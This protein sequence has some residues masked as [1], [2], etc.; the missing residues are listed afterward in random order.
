[1]LPVFDLSTPV[2]DFGASCAPLQGHRAWLLW[3][4]LAYKVLLP[5]RSNDA[6]NLFQR[7]LLAMCRAGVKTPSE[8]EAR[9]ALPRELVTF[10]LEQLREMGMLA[11][12]DVPTPRAL[13]LLDDSDDALEA[14]DAGYVFV[15]GHSG[16]L[17]PRLHR[18]SLAVVEAEFDDKAPATRA[19]ARFSRGPVGHREH[20]KA[21]VLWCGESA[22]GGRPPTTFEII[23]AARRQRRRERAFA[24]EHH[25]AEPSTDV[26]PSGGE[27]ARAAFERARLVSSVPEPILVA[28]FV[29][30]PADARH[31]SW[32]ITDPCGLGI[33]DVLRDGL[34]RLANQGTGS[35][36]GLLTRL[37]GEARRVDP[38]DLAHYLAEADRAAGERVAQQLGGAARRLPADVVQRLVHA[39]ERLT[40]ARSRATRSIKQVEGYLG[41]VY[42]AL[43][44]VFGWLMGLYAD[45]AVLAALSSSPTGNSAILQRIAEALGFSIGGGT[46]SLLG[47]SRT[48]VKA[49]LD[50]GNKSLAGSLAAGL[51]AAQIRHDHPFR[52][53]GARCP[54]ALEFLADLAR[55]RNSASHATAA[56]PTLEIALATRDR[57]VALL[58]AIVGSDAVPTTASVSAPPEIAW[59]ADLILRMR[60]RA[61]HEVLEYEGIDEHQALRT[62][63]IDLHLAAIVLELLAAS[64]PHG[65]AGVASRVLDFA[66]AAAIA[67]EAAVAAIEQASPS[68]AA[69]AARITEDDQANDALFAG[70]AAA[71]GFTLASTG[72]LPPALGRARTDRIRR[73]AQGRQS[74]LSAGLLAQV[75]TA[76][77]DEAHPLRRVA[78]EAPSF[79]LDVAR[80]VEIRGHA[81]EVHL[82]LADAA[83]LRDLVRDNV[84]AVLAALD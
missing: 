37:T 47:V 78:H 71:L 10:V 72:T 4:A 31:R 5:A 34:T 40:A 44:G 42:A 13:R 61:E 50:G 2:V 21:T 28:A 73:A 26:D 76:A 80:I 46:A 38:G 45:P 52:A 9:L 84:R 11:A 67:L 6:F 48:V 54:D 62:R 69:A 49:A 25:G 8:L 17:W 39:E 58:V 7:A 43:E 27:P 82:E 53:L 64:P 81:D 66:L 3:P 18:G 79:L 83:R 16:R 60:A 33:S 51:L 23:K 1:M 41:H 55:L 65:S 57:T 22:V 77:N 36:R 30:V 56:I 70:T 74:T 14:E 24:R 68:S 75:L 35:A 63:L 19:P 12:G 29:L 20:I 15:D 59:G 32:L